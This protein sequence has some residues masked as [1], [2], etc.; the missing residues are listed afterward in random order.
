MMLTKSITKEQ[1]YPIRQA[2]LR[3]GKPIESC[4]FDGDELATTHHFGLFIANE[5]SAVVSVYEKSN[6]L[7]KQKKQL[8]VRGMAVLESYQNSGLGRV[9]MEKVEEYAHKNNSELLWF[10]ARETAL[11]F[12]KKLQYEPIGPAFEIENVGTHYIM[13]KK[14]V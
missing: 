12:Y 2:I 9:L 10:N 11:K 14:I 4:F 8:Q 7:F 6:T 5:L 3:P 1:T 13:Y